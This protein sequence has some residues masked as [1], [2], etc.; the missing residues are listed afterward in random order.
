MVRADEDGDD[1][2]DD[3]GDYGFPS[4]RIPQARRMTQLSLLPIHPYQ[5]RG[6]GLDW[7]LALLCPQ[8]QAH[9]RCPEGLQSGLQSQCG[10]ASSRRL[11]STAHKGP[12]RTACPHISRKYNKQPPEVIRSHKARTIPR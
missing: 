5:A 4:L 9:I 12:F 2:D 3:G 10:I 11:A 6:R 8:A 7:L 1:A